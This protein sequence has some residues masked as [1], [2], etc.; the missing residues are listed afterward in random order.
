LYPC[1]LLVI[2]W[3]KIQFLKI[4]RNFKKSKQLD[5]WES[6]FSNEMKYTRNRKLLFTEM[7]VSLQI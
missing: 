4:L 5:Y 1:K 2:I 3:R 7:K 6:A